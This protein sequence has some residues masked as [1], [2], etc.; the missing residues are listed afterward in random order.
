MLSKEDIVAMENDVMDT[1][2]DWNYTATIC[3]P[4]PLDQQSHWNEKLREFNGDI[5]YNE[6]KD[7]PVGCLDEDD[8]KEINDV[9]GDINGGNVVLYVPIRYKYNGLMTDVPISND[10]IKIIF[11]NNSWRISSWKKMIGEY[12]LVIYRNNV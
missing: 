7:V 3:I 10:D 4:K 2:N 8:T 5:D 11:E 12:R 9:A 1:I 6:Y